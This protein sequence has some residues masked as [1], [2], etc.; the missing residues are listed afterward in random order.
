MS[1]L[2]DAIDKA[3]KTILR[4]KYTVAMVGAGMSV[5]SGIPPFRGPGGLWTKYGEPD[6]RSFERFLDDPRGWWE[7]YA[8][9]EGYVKELIETIE[10]A[11]P[12][13]AHYALVELEEMG[14][15][16]HTISQNVDNLHVRAGSKK[17]SEIH[18]NMFK[19]RCISCHKR[20][21]MDEI[22]KDVLP[23]HCPHC[24]GLVKTDGVMFGEP[25]PPYVLDS[26]YAETGKCDCM[27]LM[28]TSGTV[29]P[30][31]GFPSTARSNGAVLI[32]VNPYET[33]FTEGC[34]IVLRAPAAECFPPVVERI[35]EMP[36][37]R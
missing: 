26:S 2:T 10:A 30:A 17:L 24:N 19:L 12:N 8:K 18:G 20:F 22:G 28:G 14:V 27:I 31:A 1:E 3:A 35:K 4:S 6:G 16:K 9:Q 34:D 29:Y 15:L 33:P 23:P 5:E 21:E 7:S 13:P 25:I 11:E 32:E 37:R 36:E